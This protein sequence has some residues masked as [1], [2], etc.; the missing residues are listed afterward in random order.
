MSK[1]EK[2]SIGF[3]F[4]IATSGLVIGL[5]TEGANFSRSG[6]LIVIVGVI[7]GFFDLP[8]RLADID[9]WVRK[10]AEKNRQNVLI[11]NKIDGIGVAVSG[12]VYDSVV[13]ELIEQLNK[14]AKK[15]RRRLFAVEGLILVTGT[16]IWGFGDLLIPAPYCAS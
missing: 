15:A 13:E 12:E 10:E 1:Y 2:M 5:Y 4:L 7:Y 6:S 11:E 14:K 9:S 8:N 3:S 16:A